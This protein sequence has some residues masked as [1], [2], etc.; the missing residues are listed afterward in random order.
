MSDPVTE[1]LITVHILGLPLD[2]RQRATEHA[3]ELHRE[4][5]LLAQQVDRGDAGLPTRLVELM[6]AL[7]GRYNAFTA[8]QEDELDAA[9]AAGRTTIDLTFRVP[10]H[11]AD[12]ASAIGA[13]LEEAD[14]YCR[15]GRHLLTLATP[16]DLVAYR[17]WFLG[18]FIAQS[19]GAPPTPWPA[20]G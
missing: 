19:S 11:V 12:A 9:T 14:A 5:T 7:R 4:F 17:H 2:L 16:A 8:E 10:R 6:R 18:E 20:A 1:D 15:E 3:E 13:L